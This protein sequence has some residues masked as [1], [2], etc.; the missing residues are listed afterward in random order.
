MM[1]YSH[2]ANSVEFYRKRGYVYVQ[3]APWVVGRDAYYS[4]KPP[5][6]RDF[7]IDDG[8]VYGNGNPIQKYAVASGEQSFVQMLLDGQPLKRALCVTPCY[9][10]EDW[11][12][13]HRPWFMK[14]ELINAHDVDDGHLMHMVHEA[15]SFFEQF[16]PHVRVIR[17]RVGYDIVEKDSRM[18]LGSYGIRDV[19][20]RDQNLRW[21]YGTGCAEP[22]LST[23]MEQYQCEA[24]ARRRNP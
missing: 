24:L 8:S 14:A 5:E 22:R 4:T 12:V 18:E 17:T 15:C 16:L 13:W 19:T 23:V 9:R 11:N 3:D 1:D 20:V 2:I 7:R 10:I 6:A 21:I